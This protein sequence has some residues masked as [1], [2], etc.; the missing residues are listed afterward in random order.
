M[1]QLQDL[2][3]KFAFQVGRHDVVKEELKR[4][5]SE[6]KKELP[7]LVNIQRM[8]VDDSIKSEAKH[9]EDEIRP[10]I[11]CLQEVFSKP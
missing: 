7:S 6:L 5:L 9:M 2:N 8:N 4:C 10:I 1:E 3:K 11:L